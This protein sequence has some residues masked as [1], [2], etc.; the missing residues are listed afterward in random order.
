MLIGRCSF[1]TI[2][3]TH[4]ARRTGELTGHRQAAEVSVSVILR[5]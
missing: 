5:L 1:N 2:R 3:V 4:E